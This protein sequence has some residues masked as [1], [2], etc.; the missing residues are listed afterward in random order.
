MCQGKPSKLRDTAVL[1]VTLMLFWLMLSGKLDTDVLI[2]GAVA[3][4]IIVLLY[5]DGLSFFTEFRFTPQAI[6]AGFRYYG[7]FLRELFKSNL[8]MAA[9]VLSPSLP[10]TPGIVKVRTRLKSRMGRLMLA[11]SITLTPG[12]LT[13]EMAGEWL[14]I[15]CVT[16]GAT[17]I[18]A[19]TAEIVSGFE[20]YLE[21][22]YG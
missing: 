20:S 21:V 5:R 18:E 17:D 2:V 7:Y 22:M 11:N 16:L 14:Y 8:K 10:I 9:I 12:T 19:A 15:H 4:L 13:V 6:V 3:S 1:F